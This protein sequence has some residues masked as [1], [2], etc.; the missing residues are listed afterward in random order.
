MTTR[1]TATYGDWHMSIE[2]KEYCATFKAV[3]S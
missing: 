3:P 1:R 2:P